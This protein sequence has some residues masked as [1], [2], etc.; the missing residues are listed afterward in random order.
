MS[1]NRQNKSLNLTKNDIIKKANFLSKSYFTELN[2]NQKRAVNNLDGP[3]LVLSGAGTGKTRVLT[4]RLANL[5]YSGKAKPWNILAVT[6]TN[7]AAREMRLRLESLIGSDANSLWLG[8][9]HSIAAR[10]LRQHPEIVNLKSNFTIINPDDQKKLLKELIIFENLDEKK[11]TPQFVSNLIN[12]WKDKGLSWIDIIDSEQNELL[13][14]KSGKIYKDYQKR[15]IDLN[16]V[17]FADLILHNLTIFRENG[18]LLENFK[19]K[20]NYFLVDEYQDTNTAQYLWLKIIV[21]PENN[22]CC[23]GDDDQSIYGWRGAQVGNILGFER[24]YLNAEI[25]RLEQNYRSSQN[26]LNAANHLISYNKSRLGKSLKTSKGEG[27]KIKIMSFWD[28]NDETRKISN[29]IED[30]ISKGIN[31]NQIAVLVRAGYQTRS[32]EERFVQIGLPYRVVGT[33]FY[34]R[35]EIRDALSYFRIVVQNSDDLALARIINSPKR[36]IGSQTLNTI[37][38]HARTENISMF[39]AIEELILTDEFRP[40][41]K[42]NLSDLIALFHQWK[43]NLNLISHIDLG[44]KILEESLY[45]ENLKNEK[46]AEAEM[47]IENLK[48][49]INGMSSFDNMMGFLEHISLV[50]D[51]ETNNNEGEIS[52]MTLH[53]AKGLEFEAVFLPCWEEGSFPSQRSLDEKG[54]EGLEEERRLAYVGITRAKKLLTISYVSNRQI[55]GLWQ[56]L[57][58]S[59]F[60]NELPD[61]EIKPLLSDQET[62][63][64]FD[65][66]SDF[67]FDQDYSYNK[68]F[69]SKLNL[70]K[71]NI[72]RFNDNID[73]YYEEVINFNCGDRVFHSKFGMGII[74][75]IDNN[76][77]NVDFDK[78]GNKNVIISFLKKH[79]Q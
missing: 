60:I 30:I 69:K 26:I 43:K 33:K 61:Q 54:Q 4:A 62:N 21:K 42:K 11:I 77:A 22:I 1:E 35:M 34:E 2:E 23:V 74:K 7:K 16:Y 13:N 46:T 58:P 3:L 36:G 29:Q 28:G 32:F 19:K 75:L 31:L 65:N 20:I 45:I 79:V 57:I 37:K 56:N 8:T 76:K 50:T 78:A 12:S 55:H 71:K 41:V 5:I 18:D 64:N 66:F 38:I 73:K 72:K 52:L 67:D 17:D 59:R 14:G 39:S 68:K 15:L 10:I 24:D 51:S 44:M 70:S 9:F 25:I 40:L 47:R 49:L 6:F 53:A 27:E 48:E 63:K